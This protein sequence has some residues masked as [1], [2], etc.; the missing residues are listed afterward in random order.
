MTYFAV[1]NFS[2]LFY[3]LDFINVLF[4]VTIGQSKAF[5][6]AIWLSHGQLCAI[7]ERTASLT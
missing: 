2:D 5:L 6:N 7:L 4:Q 3:F 1:E